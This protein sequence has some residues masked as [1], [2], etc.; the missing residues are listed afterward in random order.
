VLNMTHYAYYVGVFLLLLLVAVYL[1][2][3]QR[4]NMIRFALTTKYAKEKGWDWI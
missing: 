2:H 3:R 4:K 1:A